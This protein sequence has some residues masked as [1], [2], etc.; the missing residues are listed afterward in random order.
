MRVVLAVAWYHVACT[1]VFKANSPH[2]L[3]WLVFVQSLTYYH[4]SNH[5]RLII[6]HK[7]RIIDNKYMICTL[8]QRIFCIISKTLTDNYVYFVIRVG[9][10]NCPCNMFKSFKPVI[11]YCYTKID[12]YHRYENLKNKSNDQTYFRSFP[13][14]SLF[15][16]Y[17]STSTISLKSNTRW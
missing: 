11:R 10:N 14:T 16:L 3:L 8:V 17:R 2:R 15:I 5:T 7:N 12:I 4:W 6:S 9:V 1:C 13:P